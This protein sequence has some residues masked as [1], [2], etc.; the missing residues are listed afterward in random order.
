MEQSA[1]NE[2]P[3][4]GIM[5]RI[6]PDFQGVAFDHGDIVVSDVIDLPVGHVNAERL[7]RVLVHAFFEMQ[8]RKHTVNLPVPARTFNDFSNPSLLVPEAGLEPARSVK[9][10]GF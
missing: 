3:G 10:P 1:I 4:D 6:N 7:E 9:S 2:T 5:V 8:C